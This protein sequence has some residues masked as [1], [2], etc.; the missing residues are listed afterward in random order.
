MT[1]QKRL[2]FSQFNPEEF[3]QICQLLCS[4]FNTTPVE[5]AALYQAMKRDFEK[6]DYPKQFVNR[7]FFQPLDPKFLDIYQASPV[8][9]TDLPGTLEWDD[10]IINKP[11]VM[12][13][14]QDS[15]HG[16]SYPDLVVGIPYGLNH[17]D[18]RENLTRTTT[19]FKMIQE[20]MNLGYRV[21]LTDIWKMWVCDPASPY[22][23]K[24]LSK[25][26]LDRFLSILQQEVCIPQP[27]AVITWGKTA[28]RS[29]DQLQ[30]PC[31]HLTIPH[32]SGMPNSAW[33]ALIG[34]QSFANK[35]AYWQQFLQE[36]LGAVT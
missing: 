7:D 33:R 20:V 22:K 27:K 31:K 25:V 11:T 8:V 29:I 5:I 30:L 13:F 9:A 17:K 24:M 15:K 16:Y 6:P 26:D 19:Y 23:S 12:I 28:Q 4:I 35:F 3:E 1:T 32:P 2:L 21:Y 34:K 36:H 14:G 10:G 18:S